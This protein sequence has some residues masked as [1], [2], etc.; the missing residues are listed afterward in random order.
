MVWDNK[1]RNE[2]RKKNPV[3]R[4]YAGAKRRAISNGLE[5]T[6]VEEDIKIPAHCPILKTELICDMSHGYHR[7][8]APSLDRKNPE[9]GYTPDNIWVISWKANRLKSNATPEELILIGEYYKKQARKEA[10]GTKKK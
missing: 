5:F 8:Q 3:K 2:W 10:N 6:L 9:R 7:D 1:R 4:L